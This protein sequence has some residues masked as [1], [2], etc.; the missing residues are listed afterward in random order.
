M[1]KCQGCLGSNLPWCLKACWLEPPAF[2]QGFPKW[3]SDSVSLKKDKN[4]YM[5][6][7]QHQKPN[8]NHKI[9]SSI[10][11]DGSSLSSC[12]PSRCTSPVETP[13]GAIAK[14]FPQLFGRL[15]PCPFLGDQVGQ[16]LGFH[17]FSL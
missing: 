4:H 15:L 11:P 7:C 12:S 14:Q 3:C 2:P 16:I 1:G 13:R 9:T 10:S 6:K 17:M 8:R 5:E